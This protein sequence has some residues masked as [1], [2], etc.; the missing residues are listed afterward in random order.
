MAK[1]VLGPNS[2]VTWIDLG[3]T[4]NLSQFA[5]NVDLADSADKVDVTGFS[6]SFREYI[7]GIRDA[8]VTVTFL[9]SY[10]LS[11]P[12]AVIG[13]AYYA[14]N[15]GTLKVTPDTSLSGTSAVVY[16]MDSKVYSWSPVRGGVGDANSID[17]EFAPFGTLG[18]TRGST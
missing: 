14:H 12:D 18:L 15:H 17:V 13:S 2:T 3:G 6:E 16:T 4:T 1:Q 9:Q 10:E 7:P 11:G 5:T 8:N